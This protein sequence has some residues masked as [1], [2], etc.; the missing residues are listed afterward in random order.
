[1][2]DSQRDKKAC[3]LADPINCAGF[4]LLPYPPDVLARKELH[5][6][7]SHILC[8]TDLV[9][10][11]YVRELHT[12]I[13]GVA[14]LK[15]KH[16]VFRYWLNGLYHLVTIDGT[17]F[18]LTLAK[19][20]SNTL[21][22]QMTSQP[23]HPLTMEPNSVSGIMKW[24]FTVPATTSTCLLSPLFAHLSKILMDSFVI[25]PLMLISHQP[26]PIVSN[27]GDSSLLEV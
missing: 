6:D 10:F 5:D 15:K 25:T 14:T 13:K 9:P 21:N 8:S 11:K 24:L 16:A 19:H 17:Q 2:L 3:Q 7:P 1:M 4:L 20:L 18:D 26:C 22:L 23:Y 27:F 12:M